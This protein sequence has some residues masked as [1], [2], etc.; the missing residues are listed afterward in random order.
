M[1]DT[2]GT[3]EDDSKQPVAGASGEANEPE[4]SHEEPVEEEAA[5]EDELASAGREVADGSSER[6]AGDAESSGEPDRPVET[7]SIADIAEAAAASSGAATPALVRVGYRLTIA[8]LLLICA[9]FLWV[10]LYAW[11]TYPPSL[12]KV[13]EF[14]PT[15]TAKAF[16]SYERLRTSWMSQIKD[17]L[18]LLVVSL[19]VPLVATVIGYI[20]G[21]REAQEPDD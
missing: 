19:L 18:Q 20:F 6:N 14:F 11:M 8:L 4:A 10:L 9:V 15:D 7:V 17:L 1:P 2:R 13:K 16:D 12:G 5:A 3:H 21:R